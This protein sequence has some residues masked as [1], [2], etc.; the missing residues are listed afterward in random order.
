MKLF[1]L[2]FLLPIITCNHNIRK[3]PL[4]KEIEQVSFNPINS[5]SFRLSQLEKLKAT[6]IV[7]RERDCPISEKYGP[8]LVKF[9]EYYNK[10]GIKFIFIY[11]GQVKPKENAKKDLEKFNFKSPYIIDKNQKIVK[12]LGAK[13]TGDV[14]ILNS[15]LKTVYRGPVDDQFHVSKSAIKAKNHYVK[16]VLEKLSNGEKVIPKELLAPGCIISKPIKKKSIL[17][18]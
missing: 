3:K 13:T 16:D 11:V 10:K 1:Y 7:M 15:N 14:F 2:I 18:I 4:A 12:A 5:P 9:E 8:R 17:K 6:V